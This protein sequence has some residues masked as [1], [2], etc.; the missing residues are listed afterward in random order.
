M[1]NVSGR[2]KNSDKNVK[3]TTSTETGNDNCDTQTLPARTDESQPE[4][5]RKKSPKI[6]SSYASTVSSDAPTRRNYGNYRHNSDYNRPNVGP[7]IGMS[8][9]MGGGFDGGVGG[10]GGGMG[11]GGDGGGMGGGGDGG[12]D[13]CYSAGQK[14]VAMTISQIFTSIFSGLA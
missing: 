5:K 1:G 13:G 9:S 3:K 14:Y 11:G 12:G 6:S 7:G 4:I 10:F 8:G 2:Y